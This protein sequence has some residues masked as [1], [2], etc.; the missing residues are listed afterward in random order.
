MIIRSEQ[1][2]IFQPEAEKQFVKRVSD[3]IGKEY[4]DFVIPFDDS[5]LEIKRIPIEVFEK[6]VKAGIERAGTYGLDWESAIVSFVS[7]MFITAPN[8]DQHPCFR[9]SLNSFESD[10]NFRIDELT[11]NSTEEDWEIVHQNYD[12]NAWETNS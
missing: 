2:D 12:I 4:A 1:I 8:F 7:L 10:P 9:E 6:M 11:K 5:E 3:Y